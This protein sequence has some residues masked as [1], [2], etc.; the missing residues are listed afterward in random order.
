MIFDKLNR[1]D[2]NRACLTC[3]TIQAVVLSKLYK[4]VIIK[5]P[6]KWSRL[7]SLEGLLG[8]TGDGLKY[9]TDLSI[10]TQQDPLRDSQQGSEDARPQAQL[11]EER[12]L[13][14]YLPQSSASNA[15][16]TFVRLLIV[17]LPQNRLDEF[18]WEHDCELDVS[19]LKLLFER[20]EASL[21]FLSC[22][23]LSSSCDVLGSVIEGIRQLYVESMDPDLG[24]CE[25]AA[26]MIVE[27]AETLDRL[28]L[29]FC[30]HIAH[31]FALNRDPLHFQMTTLFAYA[32]K[33]ALPGSDQKRQI[34]LSL[35]YLGLCG[36]DLGDLVR[37]EL[38]LDIDFTNITEL[39]LES[40]SGLSQAFTLLAGQGVSPK[41]ALGAL[42]DLFV[43]LENPESNISTSLESFL[44]SIH[45]LTHLQVL[46][47]DCLAVQNLEPILQV[48]GETLCT[49][50]WDER[51]GPRRSL[52][53]SNSMLSTKLGNLRVVSKH[54]HY[55]AVLGLP[56]DWEAISSSDKYH[57][58]IGRYL[59]RM[60]QLQ[61][62]NIRNLPILSGNCAMSMDH[63]V[64]GLAAMFLD[65]VNRKK[66]ST[67]FDTIAIG[68][69]LWRDINIG[70]HHVAHTPVSD[71]L[72]FRV[73]KVDYDYPSPSGLSTVLSEVAKG[74]AVSADEAFTHDYLLYYYWMD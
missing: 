45:G 74:A 3:K 57:E 59:R 69:P 5:V 36:L 24:G 17:K 32:M 48:H 22:N 31:D 66:E 68:A 38:A 19:T 50:I 49:L 67:F 9:T 33:K 56:L 16:N 15:L 65:V 11:L 47:D 25:W 43:R 62:L 27:N 39:R 71:F 26:R 54:C 30:T 55:L 35:E 58:S 41:L 10:S 72:R 40:C 13:Q 61:V 46:I 2:L 20:Q 4:K 51:N 6:Q 64:K 7:P 34:S 12:N 63:F 18:S 14:F 53:V 60:P 37:G 21:Q 28:Y 8:S 29:G 44:T 23:R 42:K 1:Y 73:Y 52:K 70:T